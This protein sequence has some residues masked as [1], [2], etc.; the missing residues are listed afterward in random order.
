MQEKNSKTKKKLIE[1]ARELF[2]VRGKKD[3]TM[4]DIA[5]QSDKGRRTLYTYFKSKDDIYKAVIENELKIIADALTDISKKD[6]EPYDKLKTHIY[7][8]LDSIKNAVTRNGSLRADFFKDIFEVERSR[9]KI[10]LIELALIMNILKDGIEKG[11]FKNMDTELISV[12][13]LN[14]LKGLEVPYIRQNI[15][16]KVDINKVDVVEFIF[17]GIRER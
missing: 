12:V 14:A 9:R 1:V 4:N 13:I 7:A 8:H 6:I 17:N 5:E 10:D 2:A 16:S 15:N 3:V 11:Q